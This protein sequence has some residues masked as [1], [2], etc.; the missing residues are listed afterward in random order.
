MY[1]CYKTAALFP[2]GVE[3]GD[4]SLTATDLTDENLAG[5]LQNSDGIIGPI[6]VL[7]RIQLFGYPPLSIHVSWYV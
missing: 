7:P 3:D 2:Y 5:N 4:T 6:V 1:T